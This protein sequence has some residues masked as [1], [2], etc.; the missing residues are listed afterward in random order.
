MVGEGTTKQKKPIHRALPA[1]GRVSSST[2][3]GK[4]PTVVAPSQKS[5]VKW[6]IWPAAEG[7][8]V[9]PYI[10]GKERALH[11]NVEKRESESPGGPA[12]RLGSLGYSGYC[13]EFPSF[14]ERSSDRT[15]LLMYLPWVHVRRP[16]YEPFPKTCPPQN[17][18][19][20]LHWFTLKKVSS[21]IKH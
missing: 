14:S 2:P 21:L 10:W 9:L 6:Y 7:C 3:K 13:A 1:W 16:F 17:S 20:T 18:K 8:S 4:A 11:V 5:R 12:R 15:K 19:T